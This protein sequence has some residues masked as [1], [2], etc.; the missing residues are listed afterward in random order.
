MAYKHGTYGELRASKVKSSTNSDTVVVYVGTAPVNLVRG[1]GSAGIINAPIKLS[2]M[3]DAQAKIGYA[4]D[5]DAFTLCEAVSEH[6]DNAVGN[7]GPIYVINV[8]DPATHRKQENT[9]VSVAFSGGRG[10]FASSTIIL[11]TIA[12]QDKEEG[13][14]YE[15]AYNYATGKV[16]ITSIGATALSGN[17]SVSFREVDPA[18]IQSAAI[19]GSVSAAGVYTGLAAIALLYQR[20][21]VVA[22]VI[23][24][25]GWSHDPEV[26]AA[27]V[28]AAQKIN[29]H[30]D[31]FVVA[32]IPL[33]DTNPIDT[34]AKAIAWK[35][36][37]GY[38]SEF[39][40]ACWPMVQDGAGHKYH[41]STV[42][43]ATMQRVDSEHNGIPFESPS[44]KPIMATG[45]FFGAAA[46]HMGYDQQTATTL[47]EKGT[48]TAVFWGGQWV[49]WGPHTAA[50]AYGGDQDARA[51]FDASIRMLMHITNGFQLRHGVR[52]DAPM[53]IN[54]RDSIISTEQEILDS[55]VG[56]GALLG[57][58]TVEFVEADNPEA[59]LIN[60]D[61]VWEI[62][63]TPTPPFKSGTA[64]V[65][66]TDEG[67]AAY[68]GGE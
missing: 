64:R 15:V 25:P 56:I 21:N 34:I 28:A 24:A 54:E 17:V 8:L 4:A 3:V 38:T 11:D 53:N 57:T 42:T 62:E 63:A 16:V 60:G 51:I 46:S 20:E 29:G 44:N 23:A 41:L 45:Q 30:W 32:D 48:T 49:L 58:P 50:Y 5:W 7:V 33:V 13:T 68:F 37:N 36:A 65:T 52:I 9:S 39:S 22:N 61:F 27:M 10:E 43:A 47:N 66:Y 1:Y 14:D 2:N 26:Y 67:F 19:I 18:A 35:A 6:F 40:K 59:N 31:A 12:I 55:Y